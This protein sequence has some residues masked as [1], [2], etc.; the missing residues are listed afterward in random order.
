M[1]AVRDWKW[2][3]D[4]AEND[5]ATV[6]TRE[7]AGLD[8][9]YDDVCKIAPVPGE[10]DV[11]ISSPSCRKFTMTGSGAGRRAMPAIL[12]GIALYDADQDPTYEELVTAILAGH[13]DVNEEDARD[14]ALVLQPLRIA[15]EG[16]SVYQAWEQVPPAIHVWNAC[17]PVLE[18]RGWKVATGVLSAEQYG[19]PQT[20]ERAVLIAR[21]DGAEARLPEPTHARF[22]AKASSRPPPVSISDTLGWSTETKLV[23]NYGTGGDPKKRGFRYGHQPAATITSKADRVKVHFPNGEVRNLLPDE[24]A[25]LQSVPAT[26]GAEH[27]PYPFQGNKG[28]IMM[29]IG[30]MVP[31]KLAQAILR[32]LLVE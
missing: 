9:P 20:R 14:A 11:D 19:V 24:A 2:Q 6:A 15:L 4:G 17:R 21:R 13:D 18:R 3:I 25:R 16:R 1:L 12:A 8:T 22:G 23:S 29:Q 31:P 7:A 5:P 28:Q 27:Q 10:V 32:A 30:N 26:W